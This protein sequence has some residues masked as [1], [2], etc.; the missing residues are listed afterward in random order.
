[1]TRPIHLAAS[2]SALKG[3]LALHSSPSTYFHLALALARPGPSRDLNTAVAYVREAVEGDP[4]EI[5]YWH[6]LG[7]L[8]AATEDWGGA[9]A[10]L[11]IGAG[12]SDGD[13][14]DGGEEAAAVGNA[15]TDS[16]IGHALQDGVDSSPNS[17]SFGGLVGNL[18]DLPPAATL[19]RPV[20]DY[21][22]PSRHERFEHALQLRLTQLA[23]IEHVD[24]PENAGDKWVEVFSWV[25]ARKGLGE[26][27][28]SKRTFTFFYLLM[29]IV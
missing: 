21:P 6:L 17:N 16:P 28:R 13:E 7:L 9:K 19:E 22:G 26:E 20:P 15:I 27:S 5:R 3:S 29:N 1:M 4:R 24:G 11:E 10:I 8:L 12:V 2:L 25:A 18:P 14:T 23:L